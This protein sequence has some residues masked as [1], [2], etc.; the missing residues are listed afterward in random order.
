MRRKEKDKVSNIF[1]KQPECSLLPINIHTRYPW[2]GNNDPRKEFIGNKEENLSLSE[3]VVVACRFISVR[4][5]LFFLDSYKPTLLYGH[6][7]DKSTMRTL[8]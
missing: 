1:C 2:W 7:L 3:N 8:R 5:S 4:I 6:S